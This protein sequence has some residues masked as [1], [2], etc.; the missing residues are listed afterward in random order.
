M[1][2]GF[3][4]DDTKVTIVSTTTAGAAGQT[5]ITSSSLD[6]AGYGGCLFIIPIG[7]VVTAAVT[8][9]KAQQ[10]DDTSGSPDDFSDIVGSSVTVA[11]DDDNKLKYIDIKRPGK[12]YLKVVVSRAT[13]DATIGGIVAIQYNKRSFGAASHGTGVAGEQWIGP[14]EGTA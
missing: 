12:R 6:M 8:T 14:A 9:I 10:S 5:A 2:N 4:S 7:T 13:Q 1:A 3:L 11:D